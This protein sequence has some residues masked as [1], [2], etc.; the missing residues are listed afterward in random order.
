MSGLG[1]EMRLLPVNLRDKALLFHEI[2]I[3]F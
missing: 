2:F 1:L 3:G